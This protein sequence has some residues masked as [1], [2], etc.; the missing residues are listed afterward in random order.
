MLMMKCSSH[1]RT[2]RNI[3]SFH[4]CRSSTGLPTVHIDFQRVCMQDSALASRKTG[5]SLLAS[6][7][8]EYMKRSRPGRS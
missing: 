3:K 6:Q 1:I 8:E 5:F 4:S 7:L 2:S